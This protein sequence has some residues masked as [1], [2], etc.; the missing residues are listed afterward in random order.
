MHTTNGGL[1]EP[2]AEKQTQ[3][4]LSYTGDEGVKPRV[5]DFWVTTY[6]RQT[7]TDITVMELT[8][9]EGQMIAARSAST[10]RH[11]HH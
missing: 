8:Q 10:R 2:T 11:T 1:S 4:S 9:L 7:L 6:I 5:I 3:R